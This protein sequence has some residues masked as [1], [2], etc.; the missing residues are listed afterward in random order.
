MKCNE[1]N[2]Q[3][4]RY[5]DGEMEPNEAE[6]FA[7]HLDECGEC[8]AAYEETIKIKEELKQYAQQMPKP[9]IDMEQIF[10]SAEKRGKNDKEEKSQVRKKILFVF[11]KAYLMQ[12]FLF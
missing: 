4:Y 11:K 5:I 12:Q 8:S 10:L 1:G 3:L 9:K 2:E 7:I 6:S